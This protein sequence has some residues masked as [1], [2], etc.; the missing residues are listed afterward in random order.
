MLF[1][2]SKA[3]Y[4]YST[5]AFSA[6]SCVGLLEVENCLAN[7]EKYARRLRVLQACNSE[8]RIGC[9]R[10][11]QDFNTHVR[12]GKHFDYVLAQV[13]V[14]FDTINGLS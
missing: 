11:R 13:A 5:K 7:D 8:S 12:K 6:K 9:W 14:L 3:S 4:E 10:F 1:E 2:I